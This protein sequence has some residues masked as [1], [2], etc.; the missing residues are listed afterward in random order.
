MAM[1]ARRIHAGGPESDLRSIRTSSEALA[2][3]E[4]A[5]AAATAAHPFIEH[6][7]CGIPQAD[8]GKA[9]L[10]VRVTPHLGNRIGHVQG[11]LLLGMASESSEC[12]SPGRYAAVQHIRLFRQPGDRPGTRRSLSGHAPRAQSCNCAHSDHRPIRQAGARDNESA[13]SDIVRTGA[14]G[15][16]RSAVDATLSLPVMVPNRRNQ[17]VKLAP[18][19]RSEIAVSQPKS[20]SSPPTGSWRSLRQHSRVGPGIYRRPHTVA[21]VA[22]EAEHAHA[23]LL[24]DLRQDDGRLAAARFRSTPTTS[25]CRDICT[26]VMICGGA[27]S[28]CRSQ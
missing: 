11:G 2:C 18:W 23:G 17:F 6:F 14:C 28:I 8:E 25:A 22:G 16:V 1:A 9:Y 26:R 13:C 5:E 20:V 21:L 27:R 12:C 19:A 7:W 24:E 3:C 15:F 4:L 10:Q